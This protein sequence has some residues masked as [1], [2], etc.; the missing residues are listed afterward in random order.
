MRM[1]AVG[2]SRAASGSSS[3]D[4]GTSWALARKRAPIQE[5]VA[6]AAPD[7]GF[8]VQRPSIMR[9]ITVGASG[10]PYEQEADRVA[11]QVM[12]M[13]ATGSVRA[14]GLATVPATLQRRCAACDEDEQQLRRRATGSGSATTQAPSIVHDALSSPASPLDGATRQFMEPRFG[15]DFSQVRVHDNPLAARSAQA[16]NALA[17]TVG[18]DIVFAPGRYQP[19]SSAGRQ[20][21]AHE[22][23]HVI[24][25]GSVL[26]ASRLQRADPDATRQIMKLRTVVGAGIQFWP[27]NVTDTRIGPV[28]VQPGLLGH[29]ASRLNVIIGQNLTP[30]ILARELLPLWSTATPFTP[31]G[32][33]APLPVGAL[34]EDV[35]AR[36]L[37][38]YNQYYVPV[39]AMTGWR[40]GLHFP[41]P[42]EIDEGTGIATVNAD[43]IRSL[44]GAFDAA[45]LPALD[46][47]AAATVAPPAATVTADVTAFLAA[48][49]ST[50]GR[51]IALGARAI[52]NA[53]AELPFI[54]EAFVQLG[55][56]GFEVALAMMDELVNRDLQL[57]AVQRDG[58][59]IIAVVRAALAAAPGGITPVQQASLDRANAM[60][61]R[62]AGVAAAP[63]S[64]AVPTRAE[65]VLNIETV[66]LDGSTHNPTT[67]VQV[68]S[69]IYAQCNVRFNHVSDHPATPAQTTSWIGADRTLS[70][71]SA[72]GTATAEERALYNGA[73]AAFG[74]TARFRA[75][76]VS[77]LT[78]ISASGYSLPPYCATGTA[79]PFRNV[80]VIE[81]S[82]D[83]S[84]LAH[85]LGHIL[86][87]SGAHPAGSIMQPRPRPNE[88]TDPQ[89]ATIYRNA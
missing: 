23:A 50:L 22:L 79:A 20:L 41:L 57:L 66:K 31:P 78:G 38:V 76:F 77:R 4:A 88:I 49:P 82:G 27:T 24:Q 56:A 39:P 40:A 43:L 47:R 53:Q 28:S 60:L 45:W 62:V 7:G 12:R 17:Y 69:A 81:N 1:M 51:G 46:R 80:I 14:G 52:T 34:D 59:A 73:T 32:G 68:A 37:L 61:G 15:H 64:A 29:T 26:G 55:A 54:R 2:P 9:K 25:Q 44:A 8:D 67:Q 84:T 13:P 5:S 42:V 70:V 71:A 58:A 33:G 11:E 18:R 83:N 35:L 48:E 6:L 74:L 10:D 63:P 86:L 30:R 87:N 19:S 36:A 21:I 65:K 75:F 72:C 89:C 3:S 16:V 85:E